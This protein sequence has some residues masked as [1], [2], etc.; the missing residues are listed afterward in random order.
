MRRLVETNCHRETDV[1]RNE[2]DS[3]LQYRQERTR[4][5]EDGDG[6]ALS[7]LHA[8]NGGAD[9]IDSMKH[10]YRNKARRRSTNTGKAAIASFI[11]RKEAIGY[12]ASEQESDRFP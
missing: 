10:E 11:A 3:H 8:A 9:R 5:S 6:L 12:L 2:T 7:R 4:R 1:D